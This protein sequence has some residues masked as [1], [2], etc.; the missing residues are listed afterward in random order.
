MYHRMERVA[1]SEHQSDD[2]MSWPFRQW[3][4]IGPIVDYTS[5]VRGLD[6]CCKSDNETMI[7]RELITI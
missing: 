4:L 2:T 1:T 3:N 7:W 5:V 6:G